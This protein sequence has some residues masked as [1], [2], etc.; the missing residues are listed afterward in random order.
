[1]EH[2][3]NKPNPGYNNVS[4]TNDLPT[5]A[6]TNHSRKKGL[7]QRQVQRT[8]TYQVLLRPPVV[9]EIRWAAAAEYQCVYL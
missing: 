4:D 7:H 9:R 8:H 1:L 6:T 3:H 2:C 5:D